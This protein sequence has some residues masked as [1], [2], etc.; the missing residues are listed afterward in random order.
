MNLVTVGTMK[1][2]FFFFNLYSDLYKNLKS[3]Y[4]NVDIFFVKCT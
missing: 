3:I 1:M 2:I 4:V